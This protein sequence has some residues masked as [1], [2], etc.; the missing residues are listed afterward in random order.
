[1][2]QISKQFVYLQYVQVRFCK[3]KG[4]LGLVNIV[5]M[6]SVAFKSLWLE[7]DDDVPFLQNNF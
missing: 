7:Q 2:N 1:M 3:D 4:S 5:N 6:L